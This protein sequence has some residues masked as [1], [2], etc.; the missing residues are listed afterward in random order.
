MHEFSISQLDISCM[1]KV[2][3]SGISM[4]DSAFNWL[5]QFQWEIF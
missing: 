1:Q 3:Y 4:A 2:N 5:L